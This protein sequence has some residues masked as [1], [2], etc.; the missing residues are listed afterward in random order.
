MPSTQNVTKNSFLHRHLV[1]RQ[2]R[3][4][5]NELLIKRFTEFW[6]ASKSFKT[7]VSQNLL[8]LKNG[9]KY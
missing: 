6:K 3:L 2:K 8:S 1:L 4:T 9:C 5:G 7:S